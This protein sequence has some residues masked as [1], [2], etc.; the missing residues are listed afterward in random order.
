MK[1]PPIK[2]MPTNGRWSAGAQKTGKSLFAVKNYSTGMG[3]FKPSSNQSNYL[4]RC[5]CGEGGA[6]WRHPR[7]G[8]SMNINALLFRYYAE[9]LENQAFQNRQK[10]ALLNWRADVQARTAEKLRKDANK[11]EQSNN[12]T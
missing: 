2:K 3:D 10:A 7:R 4:I 9:I 1:P 6:T 11:A 12:D 8:A 5:H